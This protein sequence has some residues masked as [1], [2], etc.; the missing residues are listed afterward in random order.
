M[1]ENP[2]PGRQSL[3]APQRRAKIHLNSITRQASKN[4]PVRPSKM[5]VIKV[6]QGCSLARLHAWS[7][8]HLGPQISG[9]QYVETGA[10]TRN[11]WTFRIPI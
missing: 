2:G 7:T 11:E 3:V 5:G 4:I 1:Q 6:L 9:L 8:T 10:L